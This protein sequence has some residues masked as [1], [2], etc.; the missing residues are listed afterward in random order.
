MIHLLVLLLLMPLAASAATDAEADRIVADFED[1]LSAI[2][3]EDD[4][5]PLVRQFFSELK[6]AK[7]KIA[8]L[9][10]LDSRYV[11]YVS[12]KLVP[13]L[14]G[15][16]LKDADVSVRAAAARA[17]GYNEFSSKFAAELTQLLQEDD[18][19]AKTQAMYAMGA[20]TDD[21]FPPHIIEHLK[22]SDK[23]VRRTAAFSLSRYGD[24]YAREIATLLA[25]KENRA[26]VIQDLARI[27]A[28]E[29]LPQIEECLRDEDENVRLTA[30]H[31]ISAMLNYK[32][33]GALKTLSNDDRRN[34][35]ASGRIDQWVALSL[36]NNENEATRIAL[37]KNEYAGDT[38]LR[39]LAQD[40][41]NRIRAAVASNPRTPQDVA[42]LLAEDR[43]ELVRQAASQRKAKK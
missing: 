24:K 40:G 31:A 10:M 11:Y 23:E 3:N 27:P 25:D 15:P 22:H 26:P 36:S 13:E 17:I 1:K 7:L 21:R 34:L 42:N 14:A 37:A 28:V 4:R 39:Q 19:N 2:E 5:A 43:D 41:S 32:L 38:L 18:T 9:G 12:K 8:A 29:F 20:S 30:M 6:T 35:A 16:L 33:A